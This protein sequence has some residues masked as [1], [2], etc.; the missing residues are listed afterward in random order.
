MLMRKCN[1]PQTTA[2]GNAVL[3]ETWVLLISKASRLCEPWYVVHACVIDFLV[4]I[5]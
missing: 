4:Q 5:N 1:R 2:L 3:G